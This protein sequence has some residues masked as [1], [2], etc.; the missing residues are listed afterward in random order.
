LPSIGRLTRYRPPMEVASGPMLEAGTWHD[1]APSGETG[2]R[3]D[4]GV[5]EGGEISMYY[6]PMIAKLCTWGPDRASAI[7]AMRVALDRFEVEG[8]G[9]NLPFLAAV[10]DHPKFISGDISTAFI[11]EEYTQ[12]FEGVVPAEAVLGQLAAAAAAMQRRVDERAAAISGAL[13]HHRRTLPEAMVVTIAGQDIPV[14]VAFAEPFADVAAHAPGGPA[15]EGDT[16]VVKALDWQP[17]E[18][19]ARIV[20]P[21]AAPMLI[22]VDQRTE[23]FRL[24]YRGADLDVKVRTARAA[25]L[26]RLMP[27][28]AVADTSKMLLCPMPGVVV[29][30]AV[31]EG[32]EV[33]EGQALCTV[34]AMKMENVL[35]A[36]R[37]AKVS[38][39]N[40]EPGASLAVDD[41]IMEFA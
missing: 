3:N 41:V 34:E 21:G 2:A 35:R 29:S 26:A 18:R 24:R 20:L 1:D 6:D 28:K 22:K 36:E 7:E 30:I 40:A 10:Y 12:G 27:E 13:S 32:D 17:G 39:I 8:I 31:A 37:R 19:L 38:R 4:T 33:Q 11:A 16:V 14:R 25:A 5:Y 23:G 15:P 9:H